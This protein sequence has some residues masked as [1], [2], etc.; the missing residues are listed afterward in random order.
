MTTLA[1]ME[2]LVLAHT[3]RPD[4]PDTTAGAIRTATLRAHHVDF[5]PRDLAEG[6]LLYT[7]LST[8]QYYSFDNVSTL[9]P[10]VRSVKFIRGIDSAT[11]APVEDLEY[12][13]IDDLYDSCGNRR[14]STYTL[15]GD[16]LRMYPQ[17]ATGS[18]NVYYFSNPN[19]NGLEYSSWIA[20]TYP[21][22][23]S[24]WAAA[25]V[26]ART[27]FT[28]MAADFQR[29]YVIPFKEMLIASHL[30]GNVS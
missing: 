13:E 8:A 26:F 25:I 7:P 5:F 22:E 2:T 17:R 3:R 23:L 18:A 16:T 15:V 12:R 27:G 4:I 20:D 10:R 28:E 19:V 9:L 14:L 6:P 24:Q 1:D 21:D 29:M 11:A 30:L